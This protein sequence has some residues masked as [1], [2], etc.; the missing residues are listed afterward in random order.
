MPTPR[1]HPQHVYRRTVHMG[2]TQLLPHDFEELIPLI[3]IKWPHWSYHPFWHNCH[4][5]TDFMCRTL[6]FAAGPKFGLFGSG[7]PELAVEPSDRRSGMDIFKIASC[8]PS[9]S[10]PSAP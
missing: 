6:G 3:R 9:F 4:H 10:K 1:E 5:F 7:D 2:R 8:F